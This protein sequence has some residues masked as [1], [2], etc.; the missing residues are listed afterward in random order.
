MDFINST[1]AATLL[2]VSKG[3]IN[4]YVQRGDFAPGYKL[5]ARKTVFRKAEVLAWLEARRTS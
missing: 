5:S 1:E 3:T 4:N 2:G